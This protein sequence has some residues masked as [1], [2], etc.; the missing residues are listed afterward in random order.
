MADLAGQ[1][2]AYTLHQVGEF[3]NFNKAE[4]YDVFVCDLENRNIILLI[5]FV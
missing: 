3:T 5:I 1:Q 4:F 2:T